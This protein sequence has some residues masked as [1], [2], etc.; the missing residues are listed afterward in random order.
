M[1]IRESVHC[2]CICH[3]NPNLKHKDCCKHCIK[4]GNSISSF[5]INQELCGDCNVCDCHCHESEINNDVEECCTTCKSCG[6]L[7]LYPKGRLECNKCISK[8]KGGMMIS[9]D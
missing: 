6:E 9:L 4:C 1:V 3:G 5:W 2:Y 7:M 8:T